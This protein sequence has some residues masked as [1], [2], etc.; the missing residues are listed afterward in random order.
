MASSAAARLRLAMA[1]Q[2]EGALL[3]REN[4]R[5]QFPAATE[6]EL[7]EHFE[8]WLLDRPMDAPGKVVSWPRTPRP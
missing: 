3:K 7:D 6:Q 5:R 4:L 2:R 8:R 1:M